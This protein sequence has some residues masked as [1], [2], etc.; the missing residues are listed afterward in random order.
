MY[1]SIK[2]KFWLSLTFAIVWA[3]G[4]AYLAE[5]W[6]QDFS[7]IVGIYIA[8]PV[9]W[10]IA[11]I[12]GFM[13]AF[14]ASSLV[15]DKR[16]PR[17]PI[18]LEDYPDITVLIAA[19]NEEENIDDTLDGIV[20]QGYRGNIRVL[21]VDDGSTDGTA[22]VVQRYSDQH[23][24]VELI[25]QVPNKGKA[26]ALNR[27][28]QEVKTDL[29]ITLDADGRLFK[30]ALENLVE[31][32]LSD[33]SHTAVVAG[34]VLARNGRN[35]IMAKMQEWDY[36]LGIGSVK[37]VQ[38][39]YHG[40]MVAHGAFS[41]YRTDVLREQ[42]GWKEVVGEDIVLTWGIHEDGYR[43]GFAEDAVL[44]TCV[45]EKFNIWAKQ[46][47]RW[48]RG[49]IEAFKYHWKLLFTPRYSALFCWWNLMFP[50]LDLVYTFF[51]LPGLIAAMF[52]YFWIAGPMTF[53]LL[54]LAVVLNFIMFKEQKQMFDSQNLKVRKNKRGL[55]LYTL[56]YAMI[57]QPVCV[58]GYLKEIVWG[59]KKDWG[60]K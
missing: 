10:G 6:V 48:S 11:I 36:F 60:T 34:A 16:P 54:P 45:P 19:Y 41:L 15:L 5:A 42:G 56:C 29:T 25:Q 31:R 53:I 33:P 2:Q 43:V 12:P 58:Y 38:S 27:G 14:L 4:S 39:M 23:E 8:V 50:Y 20:A 35:S 22:N 26:A 51:F 7:D 21:V 59:H 37:R 52:G 40:T 30:F 46:R 32:Y 44:F 49:M 24:W 28:L 55:I 3:T 13:N 47:M 18:R 9:I 1:I 57:H 17:K